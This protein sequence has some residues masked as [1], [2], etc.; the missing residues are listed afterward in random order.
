M[1]ENSLQRTGFSQAPRALGETT[2]REV[3]APR[4][5][6]PG[7]PGAGQRWER[8]P[9]P[10]RP[11]SAGQHYNLQ[12]PAASSSISAE[13]RKQAVQDVEPTTLSLLML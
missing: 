13:Q 6:Q 1:L 11:T 8:T 5:P 3:G 10:P 4:G 9:F 2:L 7:A 12:V